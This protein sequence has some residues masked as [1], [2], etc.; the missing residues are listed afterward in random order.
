MTDALLDTQLIRNL[1]F[2]FH[3]RR[4]LAAPRSELDRRR[5]AIGITTLGPIRQPVDCIERVGMDFA[6][7]LYLLQLGK[8]IAEIW[9]LIHRVF[10]VFDS[11]RAISF[12]AGQSQV[13]RDLRRAVHGDLP[14]GER[15][16]VPSP[17]EDVDWNKRGE[18]KRES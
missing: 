14:A 7:A 12:V 2:C 1:A 11:R 13:P 8:I 6:N 15:T 17:G 18:N 16:M 5:A 10:G 9:P 3:L 4:P